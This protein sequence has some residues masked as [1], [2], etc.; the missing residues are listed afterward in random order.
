MR[1]LFP[2]TYTAL[3]MSGHA[4][5]SAS[6]ILRDARR[7]DRIAIIAVRLAAQLQRPTWR[8]EA[9]AD[10]PELNEARA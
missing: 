10:F 8:C 6:L 5:E 9:R 4:P 2:R 1:V 7:G 3:V